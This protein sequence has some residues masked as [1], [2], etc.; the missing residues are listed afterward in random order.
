MMTTQQQRS[1]ETR[2]RILEAAEHCFALHGYDG[3]G[4]ARIC[5]EAG[6]SKGAFYHH[7]EGKQSVF[8]SL[9]DRWLTVMD[10]QLAQM[11]SASSNVPLRLMSMT[12]MVSTLLQIPQQQ[13][14]LYL[15]FVNMAARDP[16]IWRATIKPLHRYHNFFAGMIADGIAQGSLR[17]VDPESVAGTIVGLA[18]GLL[19]QG[20]ID[21]QGADWNRVTQE[22]FSILLRGLEVEET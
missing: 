10:E 1:E 12:G 22:A 15:E 18:I 2:Q 21:P 5:S 11:S 20:F 16:G 4:V 13:L 3:T 17:Q 9:L 19:I 8:L 6:V 14:L 7:F